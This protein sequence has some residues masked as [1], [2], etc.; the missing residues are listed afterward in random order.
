MSPSSLN[1]EIESIL[2]KI[3][4]YKKVKRK[5][6]DKRKVILDTKDDLIGQ[7][8]PPHLIS[9][10]IVKILKDYDISP[11]YILMV[12]DSDFKIP[13]YSKPHRFGY[14]VGNG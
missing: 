12:L 9:A 6:I 11:R 2:E 1:H 4:N 7:N 3:Q 8:Y 14:V 13:K 10:E 5:K